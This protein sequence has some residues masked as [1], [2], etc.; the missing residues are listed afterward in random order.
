MS[1]EDLRSLGMKHVDE[2]RSVSRGLIEKALAMRS[3]S[4]LSDVKAKLLT[5]TI[6]EMNLSRK[7]LK[8]EKNK[9]ENQFHQSQ[10]MES[11]G[12]LVGGIAHDFNNMLTGIT[13]NVYL[14]RKKDITADELNVRLDNVEQVAFQA[15]E[16][17]QQLLAFARKSSVSMK[18]LLLNSF[19]KEAAKLF[20]SS[21]PKNIRLST[22]ISSEKMLING[23]TVQLQQVL[24]NLL[25]NA[26]HAVQHQAK[27][28]IEIQLKPFIVDDDFLVSFPMHS[29]SNYAQL[30]IRDNGSGIPEE[31]LDKVFEPFF[32]TKGEGEGTGLGLPMVYGAIENHEGLINVTSKRKIGTTFDIYLPLISSEAEVEQP[33]FEIVQGN[34]ELILLVDDEDI[35][36][37]ITSE[38]LSS[39]NYRV[40][41]AKD[42][43]EALELYKQHRDQIAMVISDIVMPKLGGIELARKLRKKDAEIPV[44]LCTGYDQSQSNLGKCQ[45]N[46]CILLSKPVP[47]QQLSMIMHEMLLAD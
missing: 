12:I 11:L 19:T 16:M 21:I 25:T 15:A 45:L 30:T 41:T 37:N 32:T 17:I 1:S 33:S 3:L 23:D 22:R 26:C 35:T 28:E 9:V 38:L 43:L 31:Y 27:P 44:V 24:L 2:A 29:S 42:G 14:A 20:E 46:N 7:L 4:Y 40:M 36:L 10:K 18:P 39:V 13:G 6:F 5:E 34:G 47:I 8:V